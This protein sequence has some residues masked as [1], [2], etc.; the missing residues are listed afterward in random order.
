MSAAPAPY[1]PDTVA[2]IRELAAT[3]PVSHI[4]ADL[5]WEADRVLRVAKK[6]GIDVRGNATASIVPA[7]FWKPSAPLL[8]HEGEFDCAATLGE[9]IEAL[10]D[11]QGRLLKHFAAA[12]DTGDLIPSLHLAEYF[13]TSRSGIGVAVHNLRRKLRKTRWCIECVKYRS[14]RLVTQSGRVD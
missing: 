9:M 2:R 10:P 14:Y 7:R 13:D 6:F 8:S 3:N 12:L 4:A 11:L 5:R 1:T